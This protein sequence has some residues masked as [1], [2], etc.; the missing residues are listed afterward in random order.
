LQ[1][2]NSTQTESRGDILEKL[3]L[4]KFIPG[5]VAKALSMIPKGFI[6]PDRIFLI[7]EIYQAV[8]LRYLK[9][10]LDQKNPL[11]NIPLSQYRHK[12]ISMEI[13]RQ[14]G[15]FYQ[16]PDSTIMD[17]FGE[18]ILASEEYENYIQEL[19]YQNNLPSSTDQFRRKIPFTDFIK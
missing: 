2:S 4:E 10:Y 9:K 16:M 6:L 14:L 17:F 15:E 1:E 5:L 12:E 18:F 13:N 19:D 8:S 7:D 11:P 3:Q